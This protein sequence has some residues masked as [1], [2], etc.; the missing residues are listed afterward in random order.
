MTAPANVSDRCG[1]DD[2]LHFA[3]YTLGASQAVSVEASASANGPWVEIATAT[4]ASSSLD[5]AG[6]SLYAWSTDA[7]VPSWTPNGGS[8][9]AFVRS[10]IAGGVALI[11]FDNAATSGTVS[12]VECAL[13]EVIGGADLATAV[14]NCQSP[15]SPVVRVTAPAVST[16]PCPPGIVHVGDVVISDV[17]DLSTYACVETIDGNLEVPLGGF[18]DVELPQLVEVTGHLTLDFN[19]SGAGPDYLRNIDLPALTTVGGDVFAQWDD[20]TV[21][22]PTIDIGLDAVTSVGGDISIDVHSVNYNLGGLDALATHAGSL[23]IIGS[24]G[25]VS[26]SAFAA[27]L[28]EIGTDLVFEP[29]YTVS[30]M[31]QALETVGGNVALTGGFWGPASTG[32]ADLHT[33]TGDF[34]ITGIQNAP[35]GDLFDSLATVGGTLTLNDTQIHQLAHLTPQAL[36]V[37][38]LVLDANDDLDTLDG[39]WSV[40]TAGAITITDNPSL[41]TCDAETFVSDQAAAGWAGVSTISGNTGASCP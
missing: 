25:D 40:G 29:G 10:R 37:G 32:F 22:G 21:P 5:V 7:E 28:T 13:A 15:D 31:F 9:E 16:C 14:G 33:V 11:T 12:G 38:A 18:I 1:V 26:G 39:G 6:V 17:A 3:G 23:S 27:S 8:S 24:T 4:S 30:W 34:T 41:D 35:I 36:S 20:V 19:W 2:T